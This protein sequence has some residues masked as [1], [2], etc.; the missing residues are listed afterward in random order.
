MWAILIFFSTMTSV[1]VRCCVCGTV[2]V[3]ANL[4]CQ[5]GMPRE[6]ISLTL[7]NTLNERGSQA[8][9]PSLR[10]CRTIL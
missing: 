8:A 3:V 1:Q 7:G 6:G 9:Q 2:S 5:A 4:Y 10:T